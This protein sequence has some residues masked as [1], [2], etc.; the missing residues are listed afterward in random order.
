MGRCVCLLV[1]R[2]NLCCAHMCVSVGEDCVSVLL[3]SGYY[4]STDTQAYTDTQTPEADD[5]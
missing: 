2:L 3:D 4:S 1:L 5:G